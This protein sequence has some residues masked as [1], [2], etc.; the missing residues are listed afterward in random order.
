MSHRGRDMPVFVVE[1]HCTWPVLRRLPNFYVGCAGAEHRSTA[2]V[3]KTPVASL[4]FDTFSVSETCRIETQ[5]T[6]PRR[7][8]QHASRAEQREPNYTHRSMG[9]VPNSSVHNML[10]FIRSST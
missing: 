1:S 10:Q 2:A 4:L 5:R 8:N 7:P 6:E 9:A 3:Y